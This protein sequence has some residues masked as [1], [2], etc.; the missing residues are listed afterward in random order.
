MA[1]FQIP[2]LNLVG[3]V[4]DEPPESKAATNLQVNGGEV[5]SAKLETP[6]SKLPDQM[7][8]TQMVSAVEGKSAEPANRPEPLGPGQVSNQDGEAT[9]KQVQSND[10]GSPQAMDVDGGSSTGNVESG[11]AAKEGPSL[12]D[13]LDSALASTQKSMST[14]ATD[15]P[16][17]MEVDGAAQQLE[18]T[19]AQQSD[20]D[21]FE[22][23]S[24]QSDDGTARQSED[25]TAQQP[26]DGSAQ[27]QEA[28]N[29]GEEE[30]EAEWEADSS[31]YES[32]SDDSSDSE[33]S[34]DS[35]DE[36]FSGL[37]PQE[38]ARRLMA[39][40]DGEDSDGE[41]AGPSR[42]RGVVRTQNE[43]PEQPLPKPDV[44]ITPEMKIR[45]L[46]IVKHLVEGTI[47]IESTEMS[48][49]R[50]TNIGTVLCTAER[51]VVG[52]IADVF[53]QTRKP[54][55]TIQCASEE[56]AAATGLKGGDKVFFCE[57]LADFVFTDRLRMMKG[58]DASNY[59]DEEVGD[60][61]IEFSDDE[62]EAAYKRAKKLA[63]K[64]AKANGAAANGVDGSF[65]GGRRGGV[66]SNDGANQPTGGLNYDDGDADDDGPYRV[67]TR[68]AGFGSGEGS[69]PPPDNGWQDRPRDGGRDFRGRGGRGRGGFHRGG[70]RG[71]GG[72]GGRGRTEFGNG[73]RPPN[74]EAP[75]HH[76]QHHGSA[77][78]N[79]R[80]SGPSQ[81]PQG[82][83]PNPQLQGFTPPPPPQYG[84][85]FVT[86]ALRVS[87]DN[88]QLAN[89]PKGF[90]SPFPPAQQSGSGSL[91]PYP[92]AWGAGNAGFVPP[93][94]IPG[95]IHG[96]PPPPP[97]PQQQQQGLSGGV[98]FNPAVFGQIP[99][100]QNLQQAQGQA[101]PQQWHNQ[102]DQ[103]RRYNYGNGS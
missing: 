81:V 89:H 96:P 34:S 45:E 87:A 53:G 20:E 93:P 42:V 90:P 80:G 85:C 66:H 35:E 68:P 19:A 101:Q 83:V 24:E 57:D 28:G 55:F 36:E 91:P 21:S 47:V 12:L 27:R 13:S 58:S 46:G 71:G 77:A 26:E 103:A 52:V 60:D 16:A 84:K 29:E 22:D 11:S 99:S 70:P 8:D 7:E 41:T 97:P 38:I 100:L 65:G 56:E 62:K 95:L 14:M 40:G 76:Q 5:S 10:I 69:R 54:L 32:S 6:C 18:E 64:Q 74:S 4:K 48:D 79:A 3:A 30:G 44:V 23:T 67:L 1:S 94:P 43:L 86:E 88:S 82:F 9:P 37:T 63:R 31:P 49:V 15:Q 17:A 51:E 50:V 33:S 39:E 78:A 73:H 25:G 59:F 75:T 102:G 98:Y 72:G 92:Y 61:E 2:G